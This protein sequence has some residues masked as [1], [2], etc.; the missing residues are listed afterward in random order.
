M[1]VTLFLPKGIVGLVTGRG[2][3][4]GKSSSAAAEKGIAPSTLP[5][6]AEP[7]E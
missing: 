1:F 5:P 4:R 2:A 3:R 6:K 7:A